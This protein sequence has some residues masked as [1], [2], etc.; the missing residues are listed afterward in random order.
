MARISVVIPVYNSER[1][2]A[3]TIESVLSQTFTDIEV[4][5]V[6]DGSTD[7]SVA[8]LEEYADTDG[9]IRILHNTEKSEGAAAARNLGIRNAEGEFLS[10]L[11]SDDLFEPDMLN[12]AYNRIMADGSDVVIYDGWV[13]DDRTGEDGI[14]DFILCPDYLPVGVSSFSPE[15]NADNIFLMAIGAPWGGMYRWEFIRDNSIEFLPVINADDYGFV[16]LAFACAHRISVM[17][18]RLVHYRMFSGQ[19]QSEKKVINT[20]S[21]GRSLSGLR[22]ELIKRELYDRYRIAFG[23]FVVSYAGFYLD[24]MLKWQDFRDLY[25][26]IKDRHFIEYG[27]YDMTDAQFTAPFWAGFRNRIRDLSP[28]E[29]IFNMLVPESDRI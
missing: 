22:N 6:D 12:R 25:Q 28:E 5:C 13:Y 20:E 9:R 11:D 27:I 17:Y 16:F 3:K 24:S 7:R 1:F 18:D 23:Q 29:F 4:I 26:D 8:I 10:I 2:I 19:S 15:E 14:A 21:F